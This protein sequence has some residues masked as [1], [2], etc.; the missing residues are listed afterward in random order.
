MEALQKVSQKVGYGC[1]PHHLVFLALVLV[2]G[3][4]VLNVASMFLSSFIGFIYPAYMSFKAL[5]S[6]GEDDD[7]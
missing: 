4:L 1:K 7:K 6:K 2:G 5:E 3:L